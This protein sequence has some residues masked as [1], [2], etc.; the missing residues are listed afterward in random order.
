[1]NNNERKNSA[2]PRADIDQAIETYVVDN[3]DQTSNTQAGESAAGIIPSPDASFPAKDRAMILGADMRWAAGWALR[4]IIVVIASILL[5]RG[6]GIIWVGLLPVLLAILV[7]TVLWPPVVLLRKLKFPNALAAIT[8]ILSFFAIFGFIIAAMIPSIRTQSIELA[9]QAAVGF[10][11]ALDYLEGPPLN[12]DLNELSTTIS[13]YAS[14]IGDVLQDNSGQITSGVYSGISTISSIGLTLVLVLVLSFFFLKDGDRF[15]PM[16]R[17]IFGPNVGWHM[18]EALT[19][20][21]NTVSGF[22]RTQAIVSAVDAVFIGLGLLIL[23]VPLAFVLAV[24]T[25]FAGFIPIVGAFTMG[26]LAV[27]VA[28]VSN[29]LQTAIMTLILIIA[30]Q[31]LESNILQPILQ[32]KAM[33]LHAA[34]VL[35]SVTIGSAL[36]GIIGAFLAVP[37]AAAVAVLIRYHQELVSL[38]AG[39]ITIDDI[40]MASAESAEQNPSARN[41]WLAFTAR[42]R[43]NTTTR[44]N[45]P[46]SKVVKSE[47][48]R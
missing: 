25:F 15:L 34:V 28:L 23:G 18:N 9:N 46:T 8:V 4:F 47:D 17:R 43:Q 13:D 30:V 12:L 3:A 22:I 6:L 41:A 37:V 33:N 7:C 27:V 32:S 16:I 19:R 20:A 1:M 5:W 29:G 42:L 35:L 21:W 2:R 14:N 44:E 45:K 24:F 40:N 11:K 39:E 26:T 36:F 48:P 38:R 10:E 31:Q